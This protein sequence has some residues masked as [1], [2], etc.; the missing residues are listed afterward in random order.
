MDAETDTTYNGWSNYP[1][2]AVNLWLS[3]DRGLYEATAELVEITARAGAHH[4]NIGSG[5]WTE[6][7]AILFTVEDALKAWVSDD[8]VPAEYD[9]AT[10]LA[11]LIGYALGEVNW[12]EIATAW[13][14]T[15]N[16]SVVT[17]GN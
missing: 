1:T 15:V 3:N 11:D 13:L 2:W 6:E 8:L 5:I 10:M 14:E 4:D 7:Q 12:S 17:P 9:K 16:D